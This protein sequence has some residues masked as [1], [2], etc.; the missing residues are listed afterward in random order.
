M[1]KLI[2][3]TLKLTLGNSRYFSLSN[4]S[5]FVLDPWYITGLV[6]GEGS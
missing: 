4:S 1:K 3:Q 2:K 6:D 5:A